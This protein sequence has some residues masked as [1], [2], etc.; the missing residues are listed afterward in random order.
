MRLVSFVSGFVFL[1]TLFSSTFA[2]ETMVEP[3]PEPASELKVTGSF[4]ADNTF[5]HVVNGERN[6]INLLVENYTKRNVTLLSVTGA[7]HHTETDRLL[8]KTPTSKFEAKVLEGTKV[9]VEYHFY[10]QFKPGDVKLKIWVEVSDETQYLVPAYDSI[11]TIVE[12]EISLLDWKLWTTYL[13]VIGFLGGVGYF[14]YL[15]Y[16]PKSKKPR[17]V[18]PAGASAPGPITATNSGGY[19]EEWIPEHHLKRTKKSG[20]ATSDAE[21]SGG[22]VSGKEGPRRRKG[23]K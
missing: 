18:A 10:S 4:P 15:S 22:D 12:P 16:L 9:P 5:G 14:A 17:V 1:V 11:V 8:K 6:I 2:E 7:F 13:I 21:T 20:V 3:E 23:R 19:E